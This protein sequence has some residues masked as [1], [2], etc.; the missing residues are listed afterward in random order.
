MW[1]LQLEKKNQITKQIIFV[2][3]HIDWPLKCFYHRLENDLKYFLSWGYI[4]IWRVS[5]FIFLLYACIDT[6]TDHWLGCCVVL[7]QPSGVLLCNQMNNCQFPGNKKTDF[8][9]LIKLTGKLKSFCTVKC[10]RDWH[11][12]MFLLLN[13]VIYRYRT[14]TDKGLKYGNYG[15]VNYSNLCK[16]LK[17]LFQMTFWMTK[18]TDISHIHCRIP[19]I[20]FL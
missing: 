16:L 20:T 14:L 11:N 4:N 15:G 10:R 9:S 13:R 5:G 1:I 7:I 12:G 6:R 8:P 3:A 19:F 2:S 17:K 18:I